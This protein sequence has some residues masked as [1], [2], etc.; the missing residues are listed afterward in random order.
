[1]DQSH[2][3]RRKAR[4]QVH[5]QQPRRGRRLLLALLAAAMT[6]AL[7]SFASNYFALD[8]TTMQAAKQIS[9]LK[10]PHAASIVIVGGGLA[11]LAA[12]SEALQHVKS[13]RP[14]NVS[15]TLLEKEARTGG[16]S[17]K[18]SSGI[19]GAGTHT[20]ERLGI[21]DSAA[22]LD[23]DTQRSARG[24]GNNALTSMLARESAG[25]VEWLQG[26]FA[27][28]LDVVARLGGHSKPRTHRRPDMPDGRPQPVGWGI[29]S[30]LAAQLAQEPQLRIVT[31]AR[32]TQLKQDETSGAVAGVVYATA[33]GAEHHL[34]AHATVLATGGFA[35]AGAA[36]DGLLRQYAP[37]LAALP[38]TNGAF[39]TGDGVRLGA[40][41]G[42]ALVG[43]EHVQVHPT[44]FVRAADPS[45]P[46]KFLAAESLRGAGALLLNARGE[47]F[48]DELAT[49]DR[50]TAAINNACADPHTRAGFGG[51]EPDAELPAAFLV[52]S[53]KA[54][55]A[56]G[57]GSLGF[58]EKMGLVHRA[59]GLGA[60]ASALRVPR[61]ALE[62][63]LQAHDRVRESAGSDA[64]SKTVFPQPALNPDDSAP[65]FWAV[66]TP[67]VHYTMGGLRFDDRARVLRE[68][69]AAPIPG[70]F[71]AGEVTGGLHGANR[72][73]GNSLLECVVFG[74]EAG[75]Q[76][77]ALALAQA[78]DSHL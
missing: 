13:Q 49:R 67:S 20:Q 14:G 46:T 75:R 78:G 54:A 52:L 69:D 22:A 64:F 34:A 27:L 24:L 66:V 9:T 15:V 19:N 62:A 29:V 48:V 57:H 61:E 36:A 28:D 43:M 38:A 58:Y 6:L 11:G 77:A 71:A 50:V 3:N 73:A 39:A 45:A 33:D 70:L 76:A 42:A 40:A 56:F 55:S 10:Q 18:A 44:G 25:A 2:H 63:T 53:Q 16:N 17:A 68:S 12:A 59:D 74:R 31:G 47:R 37:Q 1:M 51:P 35:G 32:V 30:A 8:T 41:A 65:Y 21:V 4:R 5:R 72:L 7:L 60:L 26:R 23:T